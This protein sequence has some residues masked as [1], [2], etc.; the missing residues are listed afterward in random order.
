M[1]WQESATSYG[2]GVMIYR[3]IISSERMEILVPTQVIM[4]EVS[5]GPRQTPTALMD[6][7]GCLVERVG[8]QQ[9]DDREGIERCRI[10]WCNFLAVCFHKI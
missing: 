2:V 4:A 8:G 7:P 6:A 9:R 1:L 5:M 3:Q 10:P